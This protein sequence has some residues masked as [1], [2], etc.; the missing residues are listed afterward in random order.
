MRRLSI[1]L[2]FVCLAA[3]PALAQK[4]TGAISGTVTDATGAAVPNATVTV[5]NTATNKVYTVTTD[6]QGGYTI[7]ELP[8]SSYTVDVKAPNFKESVTK[9]VVVHVATTTSVNPTLELGSV[10]ESVTVQANA[11][12]VQ[13]DSASLG[14]VV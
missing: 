8:E 13:T 12:Q 2:A 11:I 7:P 3:L 14:E 6:S 10:S 1:L 9:N 4:I 5:T